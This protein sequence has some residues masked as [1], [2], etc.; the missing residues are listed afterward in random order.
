MNNNANHA[1]NDLDYKLIM[2]IVKKGTAKKVVKAAKRGR[3]RGSTI[4]LGTGHGIH[5]NATFLGIHLEPEKE[6]VLTAVPSALLESVLG[7]IVEDCRIDQPGMGLGLV[8]DIRQ[9]AGVSHWPMEQNHAEDMSGKGTGPEMDSPIAYD[10]IVTIVNKGKSDIVVNASKKAGAEGGTILYGRGS[11]I[12]EQAKLFSI[13]IEPEKDLVLTLID[14]DKTHGVLR[15]ILEEAELAE[16]GKGIAFV[17]PVERT[18]GIHH[19]MKQMNQ[20]KPDTR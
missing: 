13:L 6:I 9:I 8:I 14:R 19:R 17:L 12:H 2:T 20:E 7:A 10:L 16:P 1:L 11:G 18:V 15:T 4:L 3:A 5:E